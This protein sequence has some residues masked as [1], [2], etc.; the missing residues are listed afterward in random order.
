MVGHASTRERIFL[1]KMLGRIE[2][3]AQAANGR[4]RAEHP[5]GTVRGSHP[6]RGGLKVTVMSEHGES[7]GAWS[8]W[9]RRTKGCCSR[10]AQQ[11]IW[12][13]ACFD[14]RFALPWLSA[15]H[16]SWEAK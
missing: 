11:L 1:W 14:F 7:Q 4:D 15:W 3:V 9:L 8:E 10:W 12:R 5:G 2:I 13:Q 16:R 6:G